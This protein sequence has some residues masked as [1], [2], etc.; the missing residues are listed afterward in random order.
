MGLDPRP[1]VVA[2]RPYPLVILLFGLEVESCDVIEDNRRNPPENTIGVSKI[3]NRWVK[4]LYF[5]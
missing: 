1:L 3:A 5:L 2:D 4:K